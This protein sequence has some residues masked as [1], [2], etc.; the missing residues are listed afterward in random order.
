MPV[1]TTE[2]PSTTEG[3]QPKKT[4]KKL[5]KLKNSLHLHKSIITNAVTT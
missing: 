3:C 5:V 2:N 1:D 4:S